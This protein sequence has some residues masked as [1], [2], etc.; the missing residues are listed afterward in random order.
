MVLIAA[1]QYAGTVNSGESACGLAARSYSKW[2]ADLED[3]RDMV[4]G[5]N[6]PTR[7]H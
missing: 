7:G 3:R 5:M 2:I 1:G 4:E 6:R